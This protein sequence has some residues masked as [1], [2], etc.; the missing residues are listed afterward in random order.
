MSST[1]LDAL[2][3]TWLALPHKTFSRL[4]ALNEHSIACDC[5]G[6]INLLFNALGLP[7]PYQ[8][9]RPKALHYFA[10]LQEIGSTHISTL[11]SGHLLAWRKEQPPRSGDTG[12]VLLVMSEPTAIDAARYRVTIVD[13]SKQ[14]NGLAQRDIELH[15]D[16]AGTLVGVRLHLNAPKVKR[17]ALYHHS[18]TTSR[19][20]FGCGLPIRVCRCAQIRPILEAPPVVILRHPQERKRTLATVSLIKQ[21]YPGVLVKEGEV[22]A[23]LRVPKPALLFPGESAQKIG[24]KGLPEGHTVILIDASWRKAKKILHLNPWLQALPRLSLQPEHI[25]GYLLRKVPNADSLSSLEAFACVMQDASLVELLNGF[26]THHIQLMGAATY[27]ENYQQ[28]L[29][30]REPSDKA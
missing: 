18:L 25:S 11:K 19:Y 12:H 24:P 14:Q 23:P 8:I 7:L 2:L 3:S 29:N 15:T 28:H 26:M 20:C 17:S 16:T 4:T 21:R 1:Q 10:V 9:E 22:F 5:S 27:A 6:F 30:F 13:A